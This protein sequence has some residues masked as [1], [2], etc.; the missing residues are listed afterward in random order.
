MKSDL[1]EIFWSTAPL[2]LWLLIVFCLIMAAPSIEEV[3]RGYW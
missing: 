2:A 3:L 1:A